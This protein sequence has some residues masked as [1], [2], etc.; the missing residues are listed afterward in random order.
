MRPI[1]NTCVLMAERNVAKDV[2]S[3][4]NIWNKIIN[5]HTKRVHKFRYM[6]VTPLLE[7]Q[8]ISLRSGSSIPVFLNFLRPRPGKFTFYKTRARPQQIYS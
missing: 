8:R 3:I 4:E 7:S 2:R 1:L 6:F 5:R